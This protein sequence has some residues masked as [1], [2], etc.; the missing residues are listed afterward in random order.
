MTLTNLT[1][2]KPKKVLKA[3]QFNIPCEYRG[4]EQSKRLCDFK[5]PDGGYSVLCAQGLSVCR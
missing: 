5:L 3:R 4:S 2:E 1:G